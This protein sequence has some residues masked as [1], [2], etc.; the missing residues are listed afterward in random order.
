MACPVPYL[1]HSVNSDWAR[2]WTEHPLKVRPYHALILRIH[3][4]RIHLISF[5]VCADNDVIKMRLPDGRFVFEV[6]VMRRDKNKCEDY[7]HHNVVMETS[8]RVGPEEIA[9]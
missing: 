3:N 1:F 2:Y 6:N 9:F 5:S 4:G 7:R 8:A